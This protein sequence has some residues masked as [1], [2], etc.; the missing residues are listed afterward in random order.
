ADT[1][2]G[3][4]WHITPRAGQSIVWHNG[5]T[6]GFSSFVGFNRAT[7][8]GIVVLVSVGGAG[9]QVTANG[10]TLLEQLAQAEPVEGR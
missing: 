1:R 2:I 9:G 4:G 6:G 3:Y 8:Q 7:K 10:F 5:G